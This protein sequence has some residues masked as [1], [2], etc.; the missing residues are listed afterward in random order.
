MGQLLPLPCP[1]NDLGWLPQH[2]G[3]LL[4]TAS[5]STTAIRRASWSAS[6]AATGDARR[7]GGRPPRCCHPS[8]TEPDGYAPARPCRAGAV[9]A[10]PAR[11]RPTILR[12]TTGFSPGIMLEEDLRRRNLTINAMA[13]DD[14]GRVFDP[15]GGQQDLAARRLRHVSRKFNPAVLPESCSSQ[16][17]MSTGWPGTWSPATTT[18][19]SSLAWCSSCTGW[20]SGLPMS[21]RQ[22]VAHPTPWDRC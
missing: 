2:C 6:A 19:C 22:F 10:S 8:C 21:L 13:E 9:G 1:R 5:L 20:R 3:L 15:C 4:L 17:Q 14:A 12:L 18:C 16:V 11:G 7:A